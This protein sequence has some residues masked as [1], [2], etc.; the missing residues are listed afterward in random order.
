MQNQRLDD[1]K[2]TAASCGLENRQFAV[3]WSEQ[4]LADLK[5]TRRAVDGILQAA[6]DVV[7]GLL[8]ISE[9]PL[10]DLGLG[11]S[12]VLWCSVH[13]ESKRKPLRQHGPV[14]S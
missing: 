1:L 13:L 8:G 6:A 5:N 9:E 10:E 14:A 11:G 12:H 3:A 2:R 4:K 7:H